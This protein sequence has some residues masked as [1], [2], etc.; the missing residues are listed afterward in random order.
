MD[1]RERIRMHDLTG[2][3]LS[4]YMGFKV[5]HPGAE[6]DRIVQRLISYY[7]TLEADFRAGDMPSG[8]DMWA[9]IQ[10]Q[11]AGFARALRDGNV[12]DVSVQLLNICRTGVVIGF[13]NVHH[14]SFIVT[15]PEK[16]AAESRY[17]IDTLLSLGN[18]L[19]CLT[20]QCPEQGK[21]GYADLDGPRLL[22]DI[23]AAVPMG[24]TPPKAG[25]GAFGLVT[26]LGVLCQR[27]FM[28]I[29]TAL[30][31]A[32]ILAG[33]PKKTVAEIGGGSGTLAYYLGR[34]GM[35]Q[36]TVFD[37]PTVSILQA[38]Y[39][40][41]DFGVD[42]VWL[43]GDAPRPAQFRLLPYWRLDDEEPNAHALF[44]NQDSLPE[45]DAQIAMHY[46]DA[47]KKKGGRYL[48]SI[49][50]EGGE[51]NTITTQQ[52]VVSHMIA[53]SGGFRRQYRFPYWLRAGYVEELYE[54]LA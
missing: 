17:V 15:D 16:K 8:N 7:H 54:I 43:Y 42:A 52:S 22:R 26:E 23:A 5:D 40:M 29:Y 45:I 27:D 33:S 35:D 38:Y 48:L 32:D 28:A 24:I 31:A 4:E 11:H 12:K 49:N 14:Y 30:R 37:L 9:E 51:R 50:Q 34:A 36:I 20:V 18:A 46:L 6:H 10:T 44:I 41:R 21:W 1:R 3:D 13:A 53:Q 19:G 25:G 39:L 47:I 2:L